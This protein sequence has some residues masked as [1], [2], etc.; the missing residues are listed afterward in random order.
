MRALRDGPVVIAL[1]G[2]RPSALYA[3]LSYLCLVY[4]EPSCRLLG[5]LIL[6]CRVAFHMRSVAHGYVS[7]KTRSIMRL[8][9]RPLAVGETRVE[10]VP[11]YLRVLMRQ[12]LGTP[13]S[14]VPASTAP[15]HLFNLLQKRV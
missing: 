6:L 10:S 13:L 4:P 7:T 8:G 3:V 14:T 1:D 12:C 15:A 5:C 11:N 2:P 9:I